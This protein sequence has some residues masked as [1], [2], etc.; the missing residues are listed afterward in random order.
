M[1]VG[2]GLGVELL[3]HAEAAELALRPVPVAVV[4]A[5]LGRQLAVGDLVDHLDARDHLHREGQR[6]PPARLAARI[7][8][9]GR[10]GSRRRTETLVTAPM[11]LSI[12]S[13]R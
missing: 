12:W 11:W 3:D 13:S 8:P 5:V 10:T 7:S 1:I 4:V 9:P 6:R 2:E